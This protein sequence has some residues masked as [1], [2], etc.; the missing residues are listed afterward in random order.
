VPPSEAYEHSEMILY[1][2]LVLEE[3]GQIQEALAYL[4]TSKVGPE[5]PCQSMSLG[6]VSAHVVLRPLVGHCSASNFFVDYLQGKAAWTFY[7]R[8]SSRTALGSWSSGGGCC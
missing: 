6:S 8:T 3:G 1:R 7:C 2:A 4:D 5:S